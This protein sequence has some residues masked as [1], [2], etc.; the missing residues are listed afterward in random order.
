MKTQ[1]IMWRKILT[2]EYLALLEAD[3]GII[4]T[5]IYVSI[6]GTYIGSLGL[7][8]GNEIKSHFYRTDKTVIS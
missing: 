2:K 6:L 3:F 8:V 5:Y 1:G 4:I 7:L